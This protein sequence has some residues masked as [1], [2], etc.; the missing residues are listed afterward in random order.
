LCI[1]N[2]WLTAAQVL[3]TGLQELRP[4]SSLTYL[5]FQAIMPAPVPGM[6][7]QAAALWCTQSPAL[8]RVEVPGVWLL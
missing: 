3:V 2:V 7:A 8:H 1:V 5:S 4:L 6:S